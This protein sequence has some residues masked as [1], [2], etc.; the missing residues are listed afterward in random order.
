MSHPPL[1]QVEHISKVYR[2]PSEDPKSSFEITALHEISLTIHSGEFVSII[3]PSGS[4]KSTLMQILG[5]LD[6]P[7]AGKYFFLG[8]DVSRLSDA[9][10]ATIRSKELGFIF[11]FFNLLS[12]TTALENI[13]LPLIYA[14]SSHPT[15]RALELLEQMNMADRAYHA[16]HQLSGGQQQRVAIARALANHPKVIFADE[17]TGNVNQEQSQKIMEH[18]ATLNKQG[19][20]IVVVTHDPAIAAYTNRE[21]RIVDGKIS[22]DEKKQKYTDEVSLTLPQLPDHTLPFFDFGL[23]KENTRIGLRALLVNKLRT[24]L[25][26]LG[27]IIGVGSVI[28]MIALGQ[29]AKQSI[30]DRLKSLGSNLLSIRPGNPKVRHVR[31]QAGDYTRLSVEDMK[32]IANLSEI[33]VPMEGIA[34][35]ISGSAQVVYGNKNWN[36]RLQGVTEQYAQLYA[37]EPTYGRFLTQQDIEQRSRVVLIGKTIYENLYLPGDNPLGTEIKINRSNFRVIGMLPTKGASHWRDQDDLVIIPIST[38]MYRVLGETYLDGISVQIAEA[39]FMD[40]A[41]EA[42]TQLLRKRHKLAAHQEDDFSVRN[43]AEI[44]E[45]LSATTQ[46]MALL[47]GAIA[48]ISLIVGGI[49]IMNIMLVSVKERTREIGLRKAL[50]A[51]SKDVLFQFL[52]EAVVISLM[53]GFIGIMIGGLISFILTTFFGWL[54]SISLF[55][56]GLSFSFAFFVG[57]VFGYWPAREAARLSPV[58]ALRYE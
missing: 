34:G 55:A 22:S 33:G 37:M 10:L 47:L 44:Q 1:I 8:K 18:L 48:A 45:A 24:V 17:P 52:V 16:P 41:M 53:G 28:T 29:G 30:E 57:V 35:E 46:T 40:N 6:R 31:T 54:T 2:A 51:R 26:M 50:G 14:R 56:V 49:G 58:E 3:G 11:Q 23:M 19:V 43:M 42:I 39:D 25:A 20:T 7:S 4:G 21:I 27:I 13:A 15:H 32:A 38:A 5:L 9:E 36:T 12:R